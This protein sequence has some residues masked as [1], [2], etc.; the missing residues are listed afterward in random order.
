MA[1]V[2]DGN[3]SDDSIGSSTST[4]SSAAISSSYVVIPSSNASEAGAFD[5]GRTSY[6]LRKS[7]CSQH[8]VNLPSFNISDWIAS[9][10]TDE[11]AASR[12]RLVSMSSL[13]SE[14]MALR[15]ETESLAEWRAGS[16]STSCEWLLRP[17]LDTELSSGTSLSVHVPDHP[18]ADSDWL[19]KEPRDDWLALRT[20]KDAS[21]EFEMQVDEKHDAVAEK[22][23]SSDWL[24]KPDDSIDKVWLLSQKRAPG[25]ESCVARRTCQ[26]RDWLMVMNTLSQISRSNDADWLIKNST[27]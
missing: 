14:L 12:G 6:W 22:S 1:S 9:C 8:R 5:T 26:D 4:T 19:V 25:G 23:E 15:S 2:H 24:R 11:N 3:E 20:D 13:T 10:K 17:K 27:F 7:T 16:N 18:I 21:F